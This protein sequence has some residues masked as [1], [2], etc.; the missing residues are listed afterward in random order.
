MLGE[1]L[2]IELGNTM[3]A[4]RGRL[5]DGLQTVEHLAAWLHDM[6]TRLPMALSDSDLADLTEANLAAARQ[7][8]QAVR[9]LAAATVDGISLDP[10][11]VA[12]LN[13]QAGR[14]PRW[15]ELWLDP[16]P[17]LVVCG[18]GRPVGAVLAALA[19]EALALFAGPHRQDLCACRGPGCVLFF[20]RDHP[21]RHWCSAGCGN[22]ARAARYYARNRRA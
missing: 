14:V 1:P 8:R 20:V 5:R 11:A 13:Q 17:H 10:E 2:P 18:T 22:R 7:I 3:Y 19:E 15:R 21:Q 12:T 4:V 16:E 6:R 9:L